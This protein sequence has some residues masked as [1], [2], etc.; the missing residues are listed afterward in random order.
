MTPDDFAKPTIIEAKHKRRGPR[1]VRDVLSRSRQALAKAQREAQVLVIEEFEVEVPK[2][3][4][5]SLLTGKGRTPKLMVSVR[6]SAQNPSSS[7]TAEASN[8]EVEWVGSRMSQAKRAA[9]GL[10]KIFSH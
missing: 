3:C 2:G 6:T 4:D 1:R 10:R 5:A 9:R 7:I 8:P